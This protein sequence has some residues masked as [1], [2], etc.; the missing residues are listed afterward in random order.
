LQVVVL[1]QQI[2]VSLLEAAAA[3]EQVVIAHLFQDSL[4]EEDLRQKLH[5]L[6]L[7][8]HLMWFQWEQE[9]LHYQQPLAQHQME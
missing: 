3:E 5:F 8:L 2:V 4:V 1:E 7:R 6:H 9:G